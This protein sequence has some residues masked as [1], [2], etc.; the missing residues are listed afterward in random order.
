MDEAAAIRLEAHDPKAEQ[1]ARDLEAMGP[2][3]VKLGQLLSTRADL[4]PL[5]YLTAL[6]RLQD[7]VEPFSFADVERIVQAELNV[8][9]SKAFSRFDATPLAA[10]SLGQVH[11]AA[12]RDGREVAVKVQR[13]G[14]RERVAKDLATLE[15]IAGFVDHHTSVGQRYEV[16]GML[17]EFA[18][19]L[20]RELD[21]REEARNLRTIGANLA[22]FDLLVVPAPID[23]YTTSRVLTMEFVRG[24][25]ISALSPLERIEIDGSRLAETLFGA[26]LQQVVID[27]F[28]HA[29]PHPGNVFVTDDH[30]LALLDLG[31]VSRIEPGLQEKLLK[32][33]LA[34]SEGRADQVAD[35]ALEFGQHREGFDERVFRR[36]I[37]E[38]VSATRHASVSEI[39]V[40]R[41]ML[42]V[43]RAS[44]DSGVRVPPEL[45]MLGKTL[46]NLDEVG[47]TLDPEFDVN[48]AVS[49]HAAALLRQRLRQGLS[50][51]NAF[52][53]MI[54]TKEFLQKLPGRVNRIFDT[55]V[56]KELELKVEI[57]EQ[58]VIVEGLQKVANR[59][60]IGLVLAA[61]IVGAA[62]LMQV[63]TSFRILGYP[64]LAMLCFL[65]AAGGG[66]WLTISVLTHDVPRREK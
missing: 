19:T 48:G 38:I 54:E 1:L 62:M 61:L 56:Q 16:R 20:A 59:I 2:T 64:G 6:S 9:L 43:N 55:I 17:D 29:D 57:R 18:K 31:M 27:G 49:R 60:A 44:A 58:D 52:S 35:L 42:D 46:L 24:R 4:L 63:E 15:E 3:F 14:I 28:F 66:L 65:A 30:R 40:G 7:R 47:R 36:R 32:L 13:P 45:T 5:P 11:R 22:A 51:A 39:N 53:T 10:A 50:P 41:L 25:N 12:L 23:D 37:A 34:L 21:Y 33:L 26:Y 8:R